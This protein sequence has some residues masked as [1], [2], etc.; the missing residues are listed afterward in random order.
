MKFKIE[1]ENDSIEKE[2]NSSESDLDISININI[3]PSRPD[4]IKIG[5]KYMTKRL[6]SQQLGPPSLCKNQNISEQACW[7]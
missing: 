7:N 6:S 4:K 1:K 2:N 5:K 3:K